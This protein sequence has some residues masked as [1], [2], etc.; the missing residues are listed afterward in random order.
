MKKKRIPQNSVE[1]F[2]AHYWICPNC[3][4][5]NFGEGIVVEITK[6]DAL[7]MAELNG[8]P[9]EVCKTGNWFEDPKRVECKKC[10]KTYKAV[11][12][13]GCIDEEEF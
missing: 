5:R 13:R 9:L 8:F 7:E 11:S 10:E 3:N 2:P 4:E 1:L 12:F 6:E